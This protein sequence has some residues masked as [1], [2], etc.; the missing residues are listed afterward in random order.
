M[1][2]RR[3]LLI[4]VYPLTTLLCGGLKTI[5]GPK[6]LDEIAIVVFGE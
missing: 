2:G 4:P 6:S 1:D 5:K 3:D